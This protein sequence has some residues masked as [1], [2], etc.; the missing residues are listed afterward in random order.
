M[1]D[2]LGLWFIVINR[3]YMAISETMRK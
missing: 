3:Y 2:I 1:H